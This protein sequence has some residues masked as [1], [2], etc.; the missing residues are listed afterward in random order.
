ME[1]RCNINE[2][3]LLKTQ[4]TDACYLWR[5]HDSI[6]MPRFCFAKSAR[7]ADRSNSA[8]FDRVYRGGPNACFIG[9]S[10]DI[11]YACPMSWPMAIG[12]ARRNRKFSKKGGRR[13]GS[14]MTERIV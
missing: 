13:L 11:R 10:Q 8:E 2:D 5:G 7:R 6:P 1:L 12:Q 14:Y 4:M 3:R 9:T